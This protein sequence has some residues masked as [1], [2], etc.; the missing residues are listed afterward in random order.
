MI[1]IGPACRLTQKKGNDSRRSH[2]ATRLRKS[3]QAFS[4]KYGIIQAKTINQVNISDT[5]TISR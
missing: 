3:G 5:E 2:I 4:H 1:E